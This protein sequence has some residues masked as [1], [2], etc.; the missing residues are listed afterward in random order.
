MAKANKVV[1]LLHKHF[2]QT[3]EKITNLAPEVVFDDN[4][5]QSR[6]ITPTFIT[7]SAS[8]SGLTVILPNSKQNYSKA[9][10]RLRDEY[11][12]EQDNKVNVKEGS[13]EKLL[14]LVKSSFELTRIGKGIVRWLLNKI[15]NG[16]FIAIGVLMFL[17]YMLAE[18]QSGGLLVG[19]FFGAIAAGI[20]FYESKADL[21]YPFSKRSNKFKRE[22]LIALVVHVVSFPFITTAYDAIGGPLFF[23]SWGFLVFLKNDG[24]LILDSLYRFDKAFIISRLLFGLGGAVAGFYIGLGGTML[25]LAGATYVGAA[26]V[27]GYSISGKTRAAKQYVGTQWATAQDHEADA[28]KREYENRHGILPTIGGGQ[29]SSKNTE[30]FITKLMAKFMD[31]LIAL[32]IGAIMLPFFLYHLVVNTIPKKPEQD[33]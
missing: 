2:I 9:M 29:V 26:L 19:L 15:L 32:P 24:E 5:Y 21:V 10:Y 18:P 6:V 11:L 30:A 25:F 3:T 22:H 8:I 28:I 23:L 14:A 12:Y 27:F 13:K 7:L 33:S 1:E 20:L 16:I 4:L 17:I 31:V